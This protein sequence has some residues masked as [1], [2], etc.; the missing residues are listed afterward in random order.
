MTDV[1][2]V[3]C[4]STVPTQDS[5]PYLRKGMLSFWWFLVVQQ[6]GLDDLPELWREM[7]HNSGGYLPD[8]WYC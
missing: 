7:I 8:D 3:D 5:G 2:R 4:V 6:H 1:I